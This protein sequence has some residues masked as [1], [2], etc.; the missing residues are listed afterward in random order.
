M[1]EF[2]NDLKKGFWHRSLEGEDMWTTLQN[3]SAG[4]L[5]YGSIGKN[6]AKFLKPFGCKIIGFK[7]HI[8]RNPADS[9]EISNDLQYVIN[10]SEIV[11]V[12]LPLNSETKDIINESILKNMKGK[13]LINVGRGETVNE[14][15][16]YNAL[17]NGTLA[18]AGIDVWYNYPGKKSEP[19]FPSHK[20]IYELPNV[21]LSP[22]KSSHT[23]EAI[24]AMI[25]NTFENIRQ[26]ILTGKPG[27]VVRL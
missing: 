15:A 13:Y 2:H 11:F 26:Y 5:G 4:I 12:C 16:L 19:V 10:K 7:K 17:K 18:G 20:P 8:N 14:N 23:V 22:H 9:D 3:K 24:N 25:N 21:V 27:S 6:I 1:V